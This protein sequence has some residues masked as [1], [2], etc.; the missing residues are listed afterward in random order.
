MLVL[1]LAGGAIGAAIGAAGVTLVKTTDVSRRAG[2]LPARLWHVDPARGH[3][4][5]VDVRMFGIVFGIA[6]VTSLVF[7][8]L[9]ACTCRERILCTPSDRAA[10]GPPGR[11]A[12]ATS[13]WWD[14]S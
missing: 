7:G 11:V 12:D 14:S 1:A 2:H 8:A 4:V 9:P 5:G 13:W 10:A 3:E 6:A